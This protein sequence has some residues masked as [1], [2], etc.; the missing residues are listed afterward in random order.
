[1][2][3][4]FYVTTPIY[5]VTAKPHL[6]TLYSTILADVAARWNKLKGK[7]VFFLTGTD[8]FGQKIAQAAEIANKKPQ[9]FVDSFIDAYKETWKK[10]EIDYSRFIRTTDSDHIKGVQHWLSQ[11]MEKGEIYKS[12][13][14][15]QYC[16]PC[17]TFVT[18]KEK[19]CPSCGRDTI[20]VKEDSY[21]FKLS[22]YRDKLLN[23]YKNNPEF[24][25]PKE[26]L[27]EVVKFVESGLRDLSISRTTLK[28]GVPFP[29]D[30]AH[31]TYVWADALNNYLTGIGYPND[32]YKK[33]WPAQL[34]VL[35]KDILRFHAIYWPAFLMASGIELPKKLLVHGW[36]K[37]GDQKM[38]KSLGNVVDPDY[39]Y[40]EYGADAVRYYLVAQM[41]I[42][43]DSPF[44]IKDLEV[45]VN[46]DLVNNLGNLLN[47]TIQ[48]C[49]KNN[50]YEI[51]KIQ[52]WAVESDKLKVQLTTVIK[53][54]NELM[55][56]CLYH[57]AVAKLLSYI[58]KVN[59]YFHSNEPWK[60]IKEDKSKFLEVISIV[61]GS[62]K[63]IGILLWPVMPLKMEQL[64]HSISVEF[65][66]KNINLSVLNEELWN[67]NYKLHKGEMLF[68]K[69]EPKNELVEKEII[70][71]DINHINID[72]FAKVE[73][74]V[75]EIKECQEMPDSEKLL[76]LQVDFG[77]KGVRQILAG[78]K[79]YFK[80]LDLL[81]QK[82]VFVFNLKPRKMM[83]LESQGMML[84]V[85]DKNNN[86]HL[87]DVDSSVASGTRLK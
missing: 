73:L 29:N 85:T 3:N 24:V 33:W 28:W 46:A 55:D 47:R 41:S 63:A 48:L 44:G 8:E 52:K 76:K 67:Q 83:G 56:E 64:L 31:V 25:T 60:L 19:G 80:P 26:R 77:S 22:A 23:F 30:S 65:D 61:C 21:F 50:I 69:I 70:E 59:A 71:S 57:L 14:E 58:D 13:Y 79:Q 27:N 1:M 45:K 32:E 10:F 84:T 15:G 78:V 54:Y 39:L 11:L 16:V 37:I 53:E 87:V 5:Y 34:Q 35:G 66:L 51:P 9:E 12:Q 49:D 74:L 43:Q 72:D 38:S 4:K 82:A 42:G 20:F 18:E 17:E 75:G 68:T 62:L 86:L 81:G 7:D 40:K 2:K 36:I 6:G